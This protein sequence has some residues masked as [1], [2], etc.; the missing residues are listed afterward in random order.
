VITFSRLALLVVIA[1]GN[2]A[3]AAGKP[4]PATTA[5]GKPTTITAAPANEADKMFWLRYGATGDAQIVNKAI[6]F[7]VQPLYAQE[8]ESGPLTQAQMDSDDIETPVEIAIAAGKKSEI[9]RMTRW[10]LRAWIAKDERVAQVARQRLAT[11]TGN[12]KVVLQYVITTPPRTVTYEAESC[13]ESREQGAFCSIEEANQAAKQDS[14][15]AGRKA[16]ENFEAQ[17]RAEANKK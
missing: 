7:A 9:I 15:E 17:K 5:S 6:D 14:A 12:A 16:K 4:V 3:Y 11:A 8:T 13:L 2:S 1:L 10:S